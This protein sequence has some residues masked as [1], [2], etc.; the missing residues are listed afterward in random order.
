MQLIYFIATCNVHLDRSERERERE[1][2][3]GKGRESQKEKKRKEESLYQGQ[4]QKHPHIGEGGSGLVEEQQFNCK[5][6]DATGSVSF[7]HSLSEDANC[8]LKFHQA[9]PVPR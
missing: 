6:K 5:V 3:K 7:S 2:G 8:S 9:T 1:R 4:G